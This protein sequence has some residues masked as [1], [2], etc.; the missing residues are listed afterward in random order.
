MIVTKNFAK[1]R[2]SKTKELD[3]EDEDEE[4]DL[5]FDD[6]DDDNDATGIQLWLLFLIRK[7]VCVHRI[8][9]QNTIGDST[10]NASTSS[11][12]NATTNSS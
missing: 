12:A 1:Q 9:T 6:E 4:S 11:T 3:F 7:C 8:Q 5:A 10:K 2:F